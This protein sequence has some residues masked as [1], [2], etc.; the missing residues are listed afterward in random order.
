MKNHKENILN[1][2]DGEMY[3]ISTGEEAGG[4]IWLKNDVYFLFEVPQYGGTGMYSS[5]YSKH[6]ID[7]LINVVLGW[8]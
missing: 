8:T 2:K 1:L 7:D 3:F 5:H 4:E 6:Y